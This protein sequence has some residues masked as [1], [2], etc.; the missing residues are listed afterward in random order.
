MNWKEFTDRLNEQVEEKLTRTDEKILSRLNAESP[1]NGVP[2]SKTVQPI[3]KTTRRTRHGV[4]TGKKAIYGAIAA[5]LAIALAL[6]VM[7]PILMRSDGDRP[8]PS[9]DAGITCMNIDVNPSVEM[10]VGKDGKVDRLIAR[11]AD[12]DV[13]LSD[14]ALSDYTAL[15]ASECTA[16]LVERCV[17]LGFLLP[18]EAGKISGVKL[19][20]AG[21]SDGFTARILD[22]SKKGVEE[23]FRQNGIFGIVYA[24]QTPTADYLTQTGAQS[25]ADAAQA[26]AAQKQYFFQRQAE[27]LSDEDTQAL[28][29]VY[30]DEAVRDFF[31][32]YLEDW[33]EDHLDWVE[34]GMECG[35]LLEEAWQI[36]SDIIK[37]PHNPNILA[38]SYWD[39]LDTQIAD[40]ELNDLMEDMKE[41]LEELAEDHGLQIAGLAQLELLKIAY[42]KYTVLEK[43]LDRLEDLSADDIGAIDDLL[44][45]VSEIAPSQAAHFR[46]ALQEL[47]EDLPQNVAE[48][49]D[50][51]A[52]SVKKSYEKR[53][54]KYRSALDGRTQL[55]SD[56]YEEWI[57]DL[58]GRY[59]GDWDALWSGLG[60]A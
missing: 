42:S 4:G 32:E 30:L 15:R 8:A 10:I 13:L 1:Q 50:R 12:A 27:E 60:L 2:A 45:A 40:E 6:G 43:A 58:L 29:R 3:R 59:A 31:E 41:I 37:N 18:D 9:I 23:F 48:F 5:M 16:L 25:V 49:V 11:N 36:N 44:A 19:R 51:S 7:L 35:T 53:K 20:A 57:E 46:K 33:I 56:E 21:D 26:L 14:A 39:L 17:E 38:R 54:E 28:H 24:R 52:S 34:D 55:S 47:C 22:E